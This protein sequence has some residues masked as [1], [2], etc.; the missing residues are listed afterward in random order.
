MRVS[1]KSSSFYLRSPIC[2]H[3]RT[4]S[5]AVMCK[6]ETLQSSSECK[7]T[8]M[9]K[10]SGFFPKSSMCTQY[11]PKGFQLDWWLD[12]CLKSKCMQT[13]CWF[14]FQDLL[15]W[16]SWW[17][18]KWMKASWLDKVQMN[19]VK[20]NRLFIDWWYYKGSW[21]WITVWRHW[22]SFWRKL[23]CVGV[24]NNFWSTSSPSIQKMWERMA[25]FGKYCW[26][27]WGFCC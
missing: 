5:S 16:F 22:L 3:L 17:D 12:T 24:R 6:F 14:Q 10:L 20:W 21:T 2:I 27:W 9:T 19:Q 8:W 25:P 13:I 7:V 4:S 18:S 11:Q 15:W 23:G 26:R 1:M